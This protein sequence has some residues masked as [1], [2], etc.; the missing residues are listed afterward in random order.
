MISAVELPFSYFLQLHGIH[1]ALKICF[2]I[3]MFSVI[4]F[5]KCKLIL[6]KLISVKD[7]VFVF[8]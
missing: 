2:S 7:E 3:T 8:A 4:L 6:F 1:V 5:Q